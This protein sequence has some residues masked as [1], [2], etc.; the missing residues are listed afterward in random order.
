MTT[1]TPTPIGSAAVERPQT[2]DKRWNGPVDREDLEI[3]A[4]ARPPRQHAAVAEAT[5]QLIQEGVLDMLTRTIVALHDWLAGPPASAEEKIKHDL[6]EH[7]DWPLQGPMG[8][9]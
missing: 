9:A 5:S 4:K 7:R 2:G 1:A 8:G 6:A 3:D